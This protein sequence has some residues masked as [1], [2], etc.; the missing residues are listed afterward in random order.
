MAVLFELYRDDGWHGQTFT[1]HA[2]D[3]VLTIAVDDG[4]DEGGASFMPTDTQA[5][6]L[7]LA[8]YRHR[9]KKTFD[10]RKEPDADGLEGSRPELERGTGTPPH[11]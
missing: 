10:N 7:E 8:L 11:P 3:G 9:I 6:D 4:T 5:H 2:E 1:V